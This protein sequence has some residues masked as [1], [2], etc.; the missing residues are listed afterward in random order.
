MPRTAPTTLGLT[1]NVF[2]GPLFGLR[3]VPDDDSV[4]SLCY[5]ERR[6]NGYAIMK[7]I[8]YETFWHGR[9]RWAN[10]FVERF[11]RSEDVRRDR[12][13]AGGGACR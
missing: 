11:L 3:S 2:E 7:A 9:F 6:P 12:L 10:D 1:T 8:I 13:E 5:T 4:F